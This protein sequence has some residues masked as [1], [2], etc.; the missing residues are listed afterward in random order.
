MSLPLM[1]VSSRFLTGPFLTI[2]APAQ[3]VLSHIF[4]M[5]P[6][7]N[8]RICNATFPPWIVIASHSLDIVEIKPHDSRQE[9][10]TLACLPQ[11]IANGLD[12]L[13]QILRPC[14]QAN[15]DVAACVIFSTSDTPVKPHSANATG[16]LFSAG[17][18]LLEDRLKPLAFRP[19]ELTY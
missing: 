6:E 9:E 12:N 19:E 17:L 15:V 5:F 11:I 7:N 10:K 1:N 4:W 16:H 18:Y 8:K 3:D 13:G 14:D 2:S